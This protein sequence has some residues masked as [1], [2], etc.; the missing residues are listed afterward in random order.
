MEF[1]P[2][3][4]TFSLWLIEYGSFALFG[5]LALGIIALPVPEETLM[6]I[7]GVLMYNEK[8]NIPATILAALGGSILGITV[9]YVLGITFGTYFLQKFGKYVGLTE[10]RFDAVHQWF[11]RLGKWT[12]VIGYFIPG[13]RHLT[14]F[15]A[16]SSKLEYKYFALFG[17]FGALLWV[18]TFLSIGYFFGN[19]WLNVL[20]NFDLPIDEIMTL[21]IFGAILAIMIYIFYRVNKAA[22][23]S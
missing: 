21:L 4:E 1:L 22:S 13:V 7:A 23:K 12:L 16:G 14:G 17:Y 10:A 15:A 3:S 6:I 18:S 9:S 2:N 8:L 11:E 19:Y 20:S 5:L